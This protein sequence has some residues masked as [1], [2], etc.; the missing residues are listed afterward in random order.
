MF[1]G[2]PAAE[3]ARAG[4]SEAKPFVGAGRPGRMFAAPTADPIT[5]LERLAVLKEKGL[6]T[7][8]ELSALKAIILSS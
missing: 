4:A 5:Q 7:D 2:G 8:D 6:L 1:V 3:A